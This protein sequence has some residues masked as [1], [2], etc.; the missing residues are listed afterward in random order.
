MR[1]LLDKKKIKHKKS[2][3]WPFVCSHSKHMATQWSCRQW[4]KLKYKK[5]C[6]FQ[7]STVNSQLTNIFCIYKALF[8]HSFITRKICHPLL[9]LYDDGIRKKANKM[10]KAECDCGSINIAFPP[11]LHN[12]FNECGEK[13]LRWSNKLFVQLQ[14]HPQSFAWF[15][16]HSSLFL[17]IRTHRQ[18][19]NECFISQFTL[20]SRCS[21]SP[22]TG[23]IYFVCVCASEER[24]R[25]CIDRNHTNDCKYICVRRSLS[26]ECLHIHSC[27]LCVCG[28]CLSFDRRIK[29]W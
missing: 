10:I 28:V 24:A 16:F 5:W 9:F 25:E 2:I 6:Y 17:L 14:R 21:F 20:C 13:L 12:S 7:T 26:R 27:A 23:C 15:S 3:F 19:S 1:M 18:N 22:K 29:F 4:F 11:Q 8:V